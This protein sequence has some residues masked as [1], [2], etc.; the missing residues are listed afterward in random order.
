M[1]DVYKA[2]LTKADLDKIPFDERAFYLMAGQLAN[3]I[4]IFGKLTIFSSNKP[5]S[6]PLS[7]LASLTQTF[8]LIKLRA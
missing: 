3:D 8:L 1:P 7:Q 6:N 4:N 2:T 5:E